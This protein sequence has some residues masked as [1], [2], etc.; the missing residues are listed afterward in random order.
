MKRAFQYASDNLLCAV[1]LAF[2]LGIAVPSTTNEPQWQIFCLVLAGIL[3]SI[4]TKF[5]KQRPVLILLLL[6]FVLLGN[7]Y[8]SRGEPVPKDS[9]DIFV[10]V[11]HKKEAVLIG[12]LEKLQGFNGEIS[13]AVLICKSLRF[14]G[15]TDFLSAG[16][17]ILLSL[18]YPWP[19][20]ILP[21]DTIA[22]RATL[23]R[24]QSLKTAG[25]FDYRDY[26]AMS[27]IRVTGFINSPLFL[28]KIASSQ[29]NSMPIR[30]IME[31]LRVKIGRVIDT[32]LSP[33]N[34]GIYKAILIGDRSGLSNDLLDQFKAAGCMHILSISGMHMSIIGVFLFVMFYWLLRRSIWLILH[35]DTK[36]IAAAACL[37]FLIFYAFL[38]GSNTPVIRSLIMSAVVVLALCINRQK[39]VFATLSLAMLLLLAWKPKSLFTASF[40]LTFTSVAS[41]AA[42]FPKLSRRVFPNKDDG[43]LNRSTI[44]RFKDWLIA[45]LM[46]SVSVTIGTAPFLLY[47]FNRLSLV[48]P[49]ANMAVEPLVCFWSL[50]LGF[51]AIPLNFFNPSVSAWLLHLG[52]FGLSLS[53]S[54]LDFLHK[55]PLE[56]IWLPTP[57]PYLMA[58]FYGCLLLLLI[59]PSSKRNIR[60]P[61]LSTLAIA[62]FFFR[63]PPHELFKNFT[64]YSTITVIDV[65]QGSS[66]L[67]EFPK[68]KTALI[69]G[70]GPISPR[71]N[72]GEQV[73]APFLW[74]KGVT[75][76]D[77]VIITHPDSDHYN[78]LPFIMRH[79]NPTTI[80][81]NGSP[82]HDSGYFDLLQLAKRLKIPIVTPNG[83]EQLESGGKAFLTTIVN[84]LTGNKAADSAGGATVSSNDGGLVLKFTDG[85]FGALFP[86]D[87]S[88]RVEKLLVLQP[89]KLQAE[90]LLS[91]H[92]GSSTSNSAAFLQT[93]HPAFLIVSASYRKKGVFPTPE[94]EE[95]ARSFGIK[96]L[97]T[98]SSGCVVVTTDG[99][100][101][102]VVQG[103]GLS[104]NHMIAK[105]LA[106]Q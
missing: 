74:K 51:L 38:A 48:G 98:A 73:I 94:L 25:S 15:D 55:L 79:F 93:V 64:E 4:L 22:V 57:S 2:T 97:T 17:K 19:V 88:K 16:G 14:K 85:D 40:L 59:V 99:K 54:I 37:P 61:A 83:D 68:G 80:W 72:I 12:R 32:S 69:D 24:P 45:A 78:G 5:D 65:G 13:K 62:L 100:K 105:N 27:G 9:D 3:L 91:P 31:R 84:P 23:E 81:I 75:T 102:W 63:I 34:A 76:I 86:G 104:N 89:Q 30:S 56:S 49:I 20:N 82:G 26:L 1:T 92:H 7:F 103:D 43:A 29:K 28:Q 21:G 66:T 90:V 58:V 47:F 96:M 52:A 101:Y 95:K 60:W 44:T 35:C 42:I 87:I 46:I 36:K 10:R 67:I 41:I 77:S 11:Q 8:A 39:S 18:K 6:F 53:C 70:G 71:F 106:T 50:P 33:K